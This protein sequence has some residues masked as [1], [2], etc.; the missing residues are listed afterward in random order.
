VRRGHFD[1]AQFPKYLRKVYPVETVSAVIE[2][3]TELTKQQVDRALDN[4]AALR[5]LDFYP[6][7]SPYWQTRTKRPEDPTR[8][9]RPLH[10]RLSSLERR[11][12][13]L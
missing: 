1:N 7:L 9:P 5:A 4:E 10:L 11:V 12:R 13:D 8:A 6:A 3:K 2:V